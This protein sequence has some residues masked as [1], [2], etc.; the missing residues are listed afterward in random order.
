MCI[1]YICIDRQLAPVSPTYPWV[2]T[3]AAV[4]SSIVASYSKRIDK[5]LRELRSL[6]EVTIF[7][8]LHFHLQTC[9]E[10][11]DIFTM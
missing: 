7:E 1:L 8:I 6:F 4:Q 11:W 3:D 10:E 9:M 2:G 5:W